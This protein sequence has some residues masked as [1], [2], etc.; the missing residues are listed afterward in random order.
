MLGWF[1]GTI[2]DDEMDNRMYGFSFL[3]L[4]LPM[5]VVDYYVY[6]SAE[7]QTMYVNKE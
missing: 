4:F 3:Y 7:I 6:V 2:Q 1:I 5:R